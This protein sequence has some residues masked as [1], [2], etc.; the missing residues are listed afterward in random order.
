MMTLDVTGSRLVVTIDSL[1]KVETDL[2]KLIEQTTDEADKALLE[3]ALKPICVLRALAYM[4]SGKYLQ[5]SFPHLPIE[6]M[7]KLE[8]ARIALS[9]R[10]SLNPPGITVWSNE[11]GIGVCLPRIKR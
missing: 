7:N 4:Q 5:T 11:R 10:S 6:Q 2:K 3:N 9:I 8:E 1:D